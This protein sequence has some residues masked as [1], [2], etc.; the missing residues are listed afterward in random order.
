[1][2]ITKLEHS[3]LAIEKAKQTILIDPVEFTQQLPTHL[4]SEV[5]AI[6]ITHKHDD[7]CQ[8]ATITKLLT[9]YPTATVYTTPDTTPL[10]SGSIVVHSGETRELGPFKVQFFGQSHAAII[11]G[12]IPCDNLGVIIDGTFVNPGDSF[13]KP[14]LEHPKVLCV[15]ISAPWAKIADADKYIHELKPEIVIPVHDS[16]LSALGQTFSNSWLQYSCNNYGVKFSPLAPAA[17]LE[18]E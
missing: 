13:D 9:Q 1:M 14:P 18:I 2:K 17:S 3:G 10:I 12:Q 11:E 8:P 5:T 15:P 6:I 16:V 4:F 7:H